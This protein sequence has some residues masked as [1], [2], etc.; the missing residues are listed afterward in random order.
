[1]KKYILYL[2]LL[3]PIPCWSQ[4]TIVTQQF[5]SVAPSGWSSTTSSWSFIYNASTTGNSLSGTYSARL[6]S[7]STGNGKYIYIPVTVA[8]G[9]TYKVKFYTKR[10]CGVTVN[11]NETT[12][13]TTL[14][15]TTSATNA[16]CASNFSTWYMWELNLFS[17]YDGVAYIQILV[18]NVY[19][20]PTSVYLDDV[21][22]TYTTPISLPIELL[23]FKAYGN[24][25]FNRLKWCCATETMNWYFTVYR[26][27]DGMV[28]LPIAKQPG[29]GTSPHQTCY[30]ATD[31]N[32]SENVIYYKLT[33]TDFDGSEHECEIVSLFNPVPIKQISHILDIEGR[34]VGKEY[35]GWVVVIYSDSS[36]H[37]MYQE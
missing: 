21:T 11:L 32:V 33:Q 23:S 20:G 22:I 2:F 34:Y 16:S 26:S 18:G 15:A 35:V 27:E 4:T 25:Q 7:A 24:P 28:W 8:A 17:T 31:T 6:S 1:M 5:S 29:A 19:G 13:Q 14:I 9:N 37:L 30:Q 36:A 12:N 10:V 3:L